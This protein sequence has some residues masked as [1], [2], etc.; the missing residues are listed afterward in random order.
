ME[1]LNI[2]CD[3]SHANDRAFWEVLEKTKV[4]VCTTHSN[5]AAFCN[6]TRNLTDEMMK[7]LAAR[8]GVMGLCFYG[9]FIDKKHPSLQRFVEHILH[10]LTIMGEDHVGIGS[11][12]DG[13][14]PD[15]F[16]AIPHPGRMNNL[17]EALDKTGV[18]HS[19]LC[20]IAHGN[21]LRIF[22]R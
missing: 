19:T 16:M 13:V 6:H 20:K 9:R 1:R 11:D 10:A 21:F 22:S 3:L 4:K 12:F 15:A 7:A 8:G 2:L 5:C 14:E 17:W 18:K